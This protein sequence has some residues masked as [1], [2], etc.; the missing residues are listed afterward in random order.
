VLTVGL[1]VRASSSDPKD[2]LATEEAFDE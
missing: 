1:I 2:D